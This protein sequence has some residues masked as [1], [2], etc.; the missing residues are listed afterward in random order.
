MKEEERKRGKRE[1]ACEAMS[2][3][4]EK[5]CF[6]SNQKISVE[7]SNIY[8]LSNVSENVKVEVCEKLGI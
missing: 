2:K 7:K 5:F 1:S 3:V 4:L 8:F 6:E